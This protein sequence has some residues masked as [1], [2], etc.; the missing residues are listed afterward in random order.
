VN[1]CR[2]VCL[3]VPQPDFG[4]ILGEPRHTSPSTTIRLILSRNLTPPLT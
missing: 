2:A 1:E 3:Q 4:C